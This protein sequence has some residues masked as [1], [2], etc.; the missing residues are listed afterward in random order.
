V[1]EDERAPI[2]RT[3]LTAWRVVRLVLAVATLSA[4]TLTFVRNSG[5]LFATSLALVAAT[6]WASGKIGVYKGRLERPARKAADRAAREA[7]RRNR[8]V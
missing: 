4:V 1:W 6:V 7:R 5:W 2:W 3:W 8:E